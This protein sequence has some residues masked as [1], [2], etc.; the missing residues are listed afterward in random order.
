MHMIPPISSD[1]FAKPDRRVSQ[2][3]DSKKTD[4]SKNPVTKSVP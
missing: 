1:S 2:D 4:V 3:G